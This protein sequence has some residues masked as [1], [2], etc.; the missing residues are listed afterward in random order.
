MIIIEAYQ[1][2]SQNLP[3]LWQVPFVSPSVESLWNAFGSQT[4]GVTRKSS[5][6]GERLKYNY[7][8]GLYTT[9]TAF[10]ETTHHHAAYFFAKFHWIFAPFLASQD[11]FHANF[12]SYKWNGVI[13]YTWTRKHTQSEWQLYIR[14]CKI[15][16]NEA[17][18][19]NEVAY[20][21]FRCRQRLQ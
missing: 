20:L 19:I 14:C 13:T 18:A 2:T 5:H 4:Y 11:G 8:V 21:R 1:N 6:I 9:G 12:G 3:G 17:T 7:P 10:E 16:H 15:R